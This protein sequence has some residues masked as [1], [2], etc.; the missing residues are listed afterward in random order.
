MLNTGCVVDNV[1]DLTLTRVRRARIAS[2]KSNRIV[3]STTI[4][5]IPSYLRA[6]FNP[7]NHIIN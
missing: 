3:Y 2:T 6:V 5:V 1:N 4:G 7:I